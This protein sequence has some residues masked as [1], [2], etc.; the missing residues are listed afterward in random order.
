M[1]SFAEKYLKG[2]GEDYAK[3]VAKKYGYTTESEAD[4]QQKALGAKNTAFYSGLL[5]GYQDIGAEKRAAT[6]QTRQSLGQLDLS[7]I[8]PG[9]LAVVRRIREDRR[10]TGL[11]YSGTLMSGSLGLAGASGRAK[12]LLGQ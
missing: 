3:K 1:A 11:R 6:Q 4:L 9:M 8:S 5:S 12:T 10:R 7:S 2:I